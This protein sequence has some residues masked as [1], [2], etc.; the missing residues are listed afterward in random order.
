MKMPCSRLAP[1]SSFPKT[2]ESPQHSCPLQGSGI[3]CSATSAQRLPPG[4]EE[5][6]ELRGLPAWRLGAPRENMGCA[7]HLS[8]L[9]AGLFQELVLIRGDPHHLVPRAEWHLPAARA[10]ELPLAHELP[11]EQ[12][13]ETAWSRSCWGSRCGHGLVEGLVLGLGPSAGDAWD[14]K[15]GRTKG[16][17]SIPSASP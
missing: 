9:S 7:W 1:C 6:R 8:F 2:S 4:P 5:L 15:G 14:P 13:S 17:L 12:V 11:W 10:A 16:P 3:H